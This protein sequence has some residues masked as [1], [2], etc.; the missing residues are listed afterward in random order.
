MS[1]IIKDMNKPIE[2]EKCPFYEVVLFRPYPCCKVYIGGNCYFPYSCP[3]V[4]VPEG[5]MFTVKNGV[6]YKAEVKIQQGNVVKIP[7]IDVSDAMDG[8]K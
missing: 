3:L 4:E 8:E 2:P 5:E 1:V 6:L 7:V